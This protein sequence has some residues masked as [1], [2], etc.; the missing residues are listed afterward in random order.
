[1]NFYNSPSFGRLNTV[2]VQNHINSFMKEA[3]DYKYSVIIGSDSQKKNNGQKT[4]FVTAII[5]H[6]I[7]SGGIYFWRR[8]IDTR[9]KALKQRIFEEALLSII[10]AQELLDLFKK[11][12]ILGFN[13]EIHVD[14]GQKGATR[15][16]INEVVGMVRNSGFTVKTKPAAYGASKVADRH[17]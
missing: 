5:V 15:E 11:N 4:D 1:M 9:P 2:E 12:G 13:F 10:T 17:T 14:M 7:G 8:I 16:W 6:R 3:K